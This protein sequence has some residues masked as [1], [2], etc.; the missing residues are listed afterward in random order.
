MRTSE[1]LYG[2]LTVTPISDNN[3][4]FQLAEFIRIENQIGRLSGFQQVRAIETFLEYLKAQFSHLKAAYPEFGAD[5]SGA[6]F[7]ISQIDSAA[8][9]FR[10]PTYKQGGRN[11]LDD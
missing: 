8:R 1:Y 7:V 10:N 5:R 6:S 9:Y 2:V 11:V 3:V 4:A